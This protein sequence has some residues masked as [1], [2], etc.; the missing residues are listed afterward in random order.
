MSRTT[1]RRY[2]RINGPMPTTNASDRNPKRRAPEVSVLLERGRAYFE[3]REW[4]DAFEALSLADQSTPLEPD[5]LHRSAWSAGLT[6]RDEEMLATQERLYHARL[7]AGESLPRRAPRSG[8]AFACSRAAKPD[9][10]ADGWAGRNAW[11]S[12]RARTA[13]SRATCCCPSGRGI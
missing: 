10:R 6:A 2:V 11:S 8:S 12:G 7:D 4:N 13:S 5:D 1:R 9:A 3:R